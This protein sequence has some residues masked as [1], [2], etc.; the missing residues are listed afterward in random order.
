MILLFCM[1]YILPFT[2]QQVNISGPSLNGRYLLCGRRIGFV[3]VF[4]CVAGSGTSIQWAVPPLFA[5]EGFHD[6]DPLL[7]RGGTDA[8]ISLQRVTSTFVVYIEDK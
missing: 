5:N 1:W 4:T 3:H 2:G 8:T 6:F 7:N